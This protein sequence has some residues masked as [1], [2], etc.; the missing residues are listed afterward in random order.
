MRKWLIAIVAC[1]VL[2]PMGYAATTFIY[3]PPPENGTVAYDGPE[4]CTDPPAENFT[5]PGGVQGTVDPPE[6]CHDPGVV[7]VPYTHDPPP[8]EVTAPDPPPPPPPTG[9]QI[10][11]PRL[12]A[13]LSF[14]FDNGINSQHFQLNVMRGCNPGNADKSFA[15]NPNQVNFIVPG[16]SVSPDGTSS[17]P[18]CG[19]EAGFAFSYG[20]GYN[21]STSPIVSPYPGLGTIRAFSSAACPAGDMTCL[22][23]GARLVPNVINFASTDTATWAAKLRAHWYQQD[24]STGTHPG[25]MGIWGDNFSWSEPYFTDAHNGTDAQWDDGAVLNAQ[26]HI[27][28]LPGKLIGGNGQG[29]S[30]AF[31][32]TYQ[33]TVAGAACSGIGDTTMWEGQGGYVNVHNPTRFDDSIAQFGRWMDSPSGDG[34][35]KRGITNVYGTSGTNNLGHILTPADQRLN[36]AYACIGGLYLWAVNNASWD[37]TAIPGTVSGANFA[38]PEMGDTATFPRG[39]LGLPTAPAV[40][41]NSGQWKRVFAG[42]IVYANAVNAPWSIDGR[43]VP[44]WDGLFVKTP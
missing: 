23:T 28:Y 14:N 9:D 3:D 15:L 38:I 1:L 42:G 21:A 7:N 43:T 33:G 12:A 35:P 31:G 2:V 40:K 36:L 24:L 29:G 4:A 8:R 13:H 34:K 22:T 37:T 20:S 41:I 30:C 25:V 18:S 10:A 39:W 44:A 19:A 27:E 6:I 17:G 16:T 11:F 32:D 26:K 5:T